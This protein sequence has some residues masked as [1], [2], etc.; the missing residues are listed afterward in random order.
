VVVINTVDPGLRHSE[1]TQEPGF[2]VTTQKFS[3]HRA[4][5][6]DREIM[7]SLLRWERK[8]MASIFSTGVLQSQSFPVQMHFDNL[9]AL[10]MMDKESSFV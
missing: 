7:S 5:R 1:L 10:M 8:A 3:L 6:I 9:A 2:A 4:L